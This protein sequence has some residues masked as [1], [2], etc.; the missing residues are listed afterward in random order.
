VEQISDDLRDIRLGDMPGEHPIIELRGDIAVV[1]WEHD[2]GQHAT[3][4]EA[5][6]VYP[7]ARGRYALGTYLFGWQVA[8]K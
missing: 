1:S 2:D 5:D 8:S 3:K 6:Q 7:D 4:V